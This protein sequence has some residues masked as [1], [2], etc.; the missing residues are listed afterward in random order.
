MDALKKIEQLFG[1]KIEA[2]EP[3]ETQDD[4]MRQAQA[5]LEYWESLNPDLMWIEKTCKSCD[6]IFRYKWNSTAIGYC[7]TH[8]MARALEKIGLKWNPTK[9]P[10]ERWGRIIPAVVPPQAL[11][12]LREMDATPI[13]Q[14][15]DIVA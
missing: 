5:V 15:P 9:P 12:I 2:P 10:E 7:S 3:V 8:C 14:L 11:S 4:Q 13:D 6:K 1:V